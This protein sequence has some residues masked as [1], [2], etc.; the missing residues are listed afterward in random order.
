MRG[1][2]TPARI[3]K[4]PALLRVYQDRAAIM[5]E[6]DIEGPCK[7]YYSTSTGQTDHVVSPGQ[8]IQ[9]MSDK[10]GKDIKTVFIHKVWLDDLEP[11]QS[12]TYY[13]AGPSLQSQTYQFQTVPANAHEVRFIV[14]GDCRNQNEIHRKLAQLMMNQRVNFIVNIGELD[15]NGDDYSQ[16]GPQFFEP[17][18]GLIE[19][20][21]I[22]T[23]KGNHEGKVGNYE[24]LLVPAGEE[25]NFGFDYGPIHYFCADN[26]SKGLKE[27]TQLNL[28]VADAQNSRA[29]W[30]FVSYH[31][32]SLNFGGYWSN[33]A[34]RQALAA[35]AKADVDS[36]IT[37]HSHQY[38]RFRP[39][40]PPESGGG[41]VTYITSG[42]GGAP[43]YEIQPSLY[44]ACAKSV[45]HFCI[46]HIKDNT[47]TMDTIDINGSTIDHVEI[48]KSHG[49]PNKQYRWTAVPMDAVLLHRQLHTVLTKP[50]AAIPQKDQ[51]FT[52]T[53][54]L[55]VPTLQQ[56]A[57]LSFE[58]KSDRDMY[59]L[60][61]QAKLVSIPPQGG[62]VEVELTITPLVDVTLA[63]DN[64][65]GGRQFVPSLWV[66]CEYRFGPGRQLVE[67]LIYP[68]VVR[69]R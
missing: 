34:Q 15:I 19:S 17:L 60:P 20:V 51:P 68:V 63:K 13:I 61:E 22:Y 35:F 16:W 9:Y 67:S 7:V 69:S 64:P 25:N 32:P 5:W 2:L 39:V 12:Y 62:D 11:G 36:V 29:I 66:N 53:Y 46:F 10:Q 23:V 21:P 56:A 44:H 3:T 42:G 24:K 52:I 54:K 47:L 48:T 26:S 28:I 59:Q 18:K 33:W 1:A 4:G 65:A 31:E 55:S 30:K 58:L 8:K 41:Y 57:L 38:E 45:Y 27:Q 49:M 40:E 37:G 43:L 50:L 14:Y 6:N